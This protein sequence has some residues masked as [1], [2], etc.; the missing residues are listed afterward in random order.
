MLDEPFGGLDPLNTDVLREVI[1]EMVANGKY[2]IMSS[3]QMAVVEDYCESLVLLHRGR[4][5]LNGRLRDVKAGYGHTNLIV[6]CR[7][8]ERPAAAACGLIPLESRADER[9]YKITGDEMAHRFLKALVDAGNYPDKFEIR[10]PSLHE[11]FVEKVG[12]N[13]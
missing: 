8:D 6:S 7:E 3:H 1:G 10:E 12:D 11:I 4:A 9:E 13:K 2:V 5:V